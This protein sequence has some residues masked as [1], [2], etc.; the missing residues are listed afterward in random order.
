MSFVSAERGHDPTFP[1]RESSTTN[2][3]LGINQFIYR[4][5]PMLF[6]YL[7]RYNESRSGSMPRIFH[8]SR[9]RL[10]D[11]RGCA[12]TSMR[13]FQ[14][15]KPSL[16]IQPVKKILTQ[17][18]YYYTRTAQFCAALVSCAIVND[19]AVSHRESPANNCVLCH[20]SESQVTA[21]LPAS[22]INACSDG[23]A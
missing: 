6:D 21:G 22:Q 4:F 16:S 18:Q 2:P 5:T 20:V 14:S 11:G 15:R 9:S 3:S 7:L 12:H 1:P 13:F 8:E 17:E 23:P 19:I 10:V